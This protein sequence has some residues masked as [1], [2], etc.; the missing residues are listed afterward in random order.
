MRSRLSDSRIHMGGGPQP[1]GG[2]SP[3][4]TLRVLLVEPAR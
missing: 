2:V 4:T 3:P 1:A